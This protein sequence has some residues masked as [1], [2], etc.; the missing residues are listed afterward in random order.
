MPCTGKLREA[1]KGTARGR[2]RAG[3]A[4]ACPVAEV[5]G[6]RGALPAA[7][8]VAALLRDFCEAPR[9]GAHTAAAAARHAWAAAVP[10]A[11]EGHPHLPSQLCF[12]NS[13]TCNRAVRST[14]TAD[15]RGNCSV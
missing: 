12:S 4:E 9:A 2:R 14:I 8:A 5:A 10:E 7:G 11:F 6:H 1:C 15:Q 3:G 13:Q